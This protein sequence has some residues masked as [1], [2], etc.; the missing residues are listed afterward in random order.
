LNLGQL[1]LSERAVL[2]QAAARWAAEFV[3]LGQG[4]GLTAEL[5]EL[6]LQRGGLPP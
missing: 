6:R 2:E 5:P 1:A 3:A 4:F